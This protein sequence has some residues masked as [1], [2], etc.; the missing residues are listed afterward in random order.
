MPAINTVI[1]S[2]YQ[3]SVWAIYILVPPRINIIASEK[4]YGFH[5]ATFFYTYPFSDIPLAFV[6]ALWCNFIASGLFGRGEIG[7]L[8]PI[9]VVCLF[10]FFFLTFNRFF[11]VF[12]VF[13]PN[14]EDSFS[15]N[16]SHF[17][18]GIVYFN[19]GFGR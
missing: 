14:I 18:C 15:A 5:S 19:H 7:L 16:I 3:L 12:A 9:F 10:S 17:C 6:F 1:L 11:L 2:R 13:F 8:K 4:M